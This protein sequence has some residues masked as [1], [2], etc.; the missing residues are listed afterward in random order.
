LLVILLT[1]PKTGG[2]LEMRLSENKFLLAS[3]TVARGCGGMVVV[4]VEAVVSV[5]LIQQH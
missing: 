1:S 2:K 4:V 5:R 3:R